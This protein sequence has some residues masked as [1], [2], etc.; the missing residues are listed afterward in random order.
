MSRGEY[1]YIWQSESWPAFRWR[2]SEL[3]DLL[4]AAR[5]EQGRLLG[6][7]DALGFELEASAELLAL[8]EEAMGTAAIEGETLARAEVR[9][10]VARRLGVRSQGVISSSRR[11]DGL[12][13]ILHDATTN[14]AVAL[15]PARLQGW[16]ALLFGEDQ[17]PSEGRWRSDA[18]GPMQVVSGPMGR[19][20]VH[21]EAPR[22][23]R[24]DDEME[25]FFTWLNAPPSTD[26]LIMAGIAHLWFV[27]IHPFDDGNG[28]I[29]R[30][31]SDML[32]ARS[33]NWPVAGAAPDLDRRLS[34][35]GVDAEGESR[36]H[37]MASVVSR[38]LAGR[39]PALGRVVFRYRATRPILESCRSRVA[40]RETT[41]GAQPDAGG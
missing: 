41:E 3:I 35:P 31:I 8:T 36:H 29:A 22:A 27:T 12:V 25:Q 7:M 9:S 13:E 20:T 15:A 34:Q 37:G 23:S 38:D 30:V 33:E 10:S 6:R 24:L 28:R 19:E 21:F 16:R 14:H 4:S 39:N 1:K 2:D 11:V 17:P 32:L 26:P 5:F 18:T 40:K